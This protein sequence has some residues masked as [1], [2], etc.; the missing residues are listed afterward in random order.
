MNASVFSTREDREDGFDLR[1]LSLDGED[2]AARLYF[3]VRD[4]WW[5]TVPLETVSHG[6]R[7]TEDGF[8]VDVEAKTTGDTAP[9]SV[10]LRYEAV[11]STL[12]ASFE[13][14]ALG[15]FDYARIGF[16]LLLADS[17]YE[18]RQAVSWRGSDRTDFVFPVGIITHNQSDAA[19]LAFHSSFDGFETSLASGTR[20]T[21]RAEGERFEFEDQRN[22]TDASY[23]AYSISAGWPFPAAEGQRFGHRLQIEVAAARGADRAPEDDSIEV[24]DGIGSLPSIDV[25]A[26]R[27]S[28][29][30]YRPGGGFQELNAQRPGV[31][32]CDSIELAVNGAVH[33]ADDD[34]VLETAAHHGAIVRAARALTGG[35][36]PVRL[37]P[38]S[39]LDVAGDWRD[40]EGHYHPEPAPGLPRERLASPLA[41]TWVVASAASAVPAGVEAIRYLETSIPADAPARRAI[42]RLRRLEGGEV[43]SVRAPS[44]LAVL[45]VESGGTVTLA[46]ANP[47]PDPQPV[48]L[49]DGTSTIVAGFSTVWMELAGR[50]IARHPEV[51][52]EAS[53]SH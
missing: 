50:A 42:E 34:S 12:I 46:I 37:S 24:G 23:K 49:P 51:A 1:G 3:A 15:A 44:R 40:P 21:V 39:F 26:G 4:P 25:F 13:A 31:P 20:V 48:V 9:L 14:V 18:G 10:R 7:R 2:I 47:S 30:S 8:V 32:S 16:C 22:W 6:R 11:G 53:A 27:M 19:S 35:R 5:R 52:S 43:R 38:V 33:A 45:A 17:L 28:S 41:E 29:L 36:L